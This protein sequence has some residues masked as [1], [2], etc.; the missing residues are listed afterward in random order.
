MILIDNMDLV[1]KMLKDMEDLVRFSVLYLADK[2]R[3]M[4]GHALRFIRYLRRCQTTRKGIKWYFYRFLLESMTRRYGLEIPYKCKIGKGFYLGHAY[5]ITVN[6]NVEIGEWCNLHK[7]V[8]IGRQ[9][10]GIK[11]GVP[12][13]GNRVWI[14]VNATVVG[15]II[16]GD[17]VL[18]APGAYVNCDIPDHSVVVGNPCQVHY[19]E[20]A[21]EGYIN[22][23]E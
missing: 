16:I 22:I 4:A 7:G 23:V 12:K 8:T 20:N 13:I 14:G 6:P 2:Q 3:N 1:F 10:R 5:N 11:K 21:T 17:D 9:N 19:K 15:K 18:I